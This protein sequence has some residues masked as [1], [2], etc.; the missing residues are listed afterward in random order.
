MK[1]REKEF[2]PQKRRSN[3]KKWLRKVIFNYNKTKKKKKSLRGKAKKHTDFYKIIAPTILDLYKPQNHKPMVEFVTEI[4]KRATKGTK[5]N[6]AGIHICFRNTKY[7]TSAAGVWLLACMEN[8]KA[9]FP[10]TIFRVTSPPQTP[11]AKGHKKLY[12]I[13]DSVLNRI[14]FYSA[15]GLKKREMIEVPHVKCWEVSKGSIVAGEIIGKLLESVTQITGRDYK[16]LY[17]PLLEATANS[18]EHA[19]HPEV[20]SLPQPATKWWCFAAIMNNKLITLVCDLG[21]GIPKTLPKTQ[22]KGF[23]E[24]IAKLIGHPFTEDCHFIRGALEVKRTNTELDHRG[25][26]GTDLQSI[27]EQ[28]EGSQLRILSNRGLLKIVNNGYKKVRSSGLD[29]AKSISGTIV[30]WSVALPV[31]DTK[32]QK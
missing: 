7:I 27:I 22:G 21:V 1:L 20:Y 5:K 14:G 3:V 8:L 25:K 6:P 9:N 17:R 16:S 15:I 12:P 26:G 32:C 4:E 18:V 30:E 31:E 19:Y 11:I 23:F 13:V 2:T 24:R 28:T 10:N 29:N